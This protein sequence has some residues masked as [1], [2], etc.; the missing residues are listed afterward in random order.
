M[1]FNFDP[2]HFGIFDSE[3]KF[4]N[5]AVSKKRTVGFFEFE[6]FT[7]HSQKVSYINDNPIK[8]DRGTLICAKP[9]QLRYSQLPF[10]CHYLHISSE[11]EDFIAL[12][13]SLPDVITVHDVDRIAQMFEELLKYEGESPEDIFGLQSAVCK[14]IGYILHLAYTSPAENPALHTYKKPLSD[15]SNYIKHHL[16]EK[17]TLEKLAKVANLSPIYFHKLFCE[18]FGKTPNKYIWEHRIAAAKLALLSDNVSI[19]DVAEDCGFS[20]QSYF[21]NKFKEA[22]GMTP[23]KYRKHMLGRLKL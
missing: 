19:A 14:L 15:V 12:M 13:E 23:L 10:R 17:L 2:V 3:V 22:T 7:V 21:N 11:D 4:G 5:K 20:T 18:R 9:G 6:L 1:H 16:S 8:R